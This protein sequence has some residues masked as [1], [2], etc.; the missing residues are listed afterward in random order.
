MS[1]SQ[2]PDPNQPNEQ[3]LTFEQAVE[4]LEQIIDAIESGE[5]GLEQSLKQYEQGVKLLNHC[6]S[7][8]DRA[9]Q[10]IEQLNVTDEAGLEDAEQQDAEE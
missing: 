8:L 6:R 4:Q 3:Q 1:D 5:V 10:K 7:I 2:Q 9:E